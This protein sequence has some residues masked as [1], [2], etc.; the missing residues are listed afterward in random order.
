[1]RNTCDLFSTF[2]SIHRKYV[3]RERERESF[4]NRY[5][6]NCVAFK[7][8]IIFYKIVHLLV[9]IKEKP[10]N[11]TYQFFHHFLRDSKRLF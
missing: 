7:K 1:M 5:V 11:H 2:F 3:E 4:V 6:L 8:L 9:V 10:Q